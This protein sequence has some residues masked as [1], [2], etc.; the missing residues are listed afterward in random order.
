MWPDYPFDVPSP[1]DSG[2]DDSNR[3]SVIPGQRFSVHLVSQD[4]VGHGI[5]TLSKINADFSKVDL[6]RWKI[7]RAERTSVMQDLQSRWWKTFPSMMTFSVEWPSVPFQLESK[8]HK[9]SHLIQ[10]RNPWKQNDQIIM[11]NFQFKSGHPTS[12]WTC[13]TTPFSAS[14]SVSPLALFQSGHIK[15]LYLSRKWNLATLKP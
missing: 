12:N 15:A 3:E 6:Q 14:S 11:A 2:Y 7:F 5:E 13:F 1:D 4:Y 8:L 9:P 10:R